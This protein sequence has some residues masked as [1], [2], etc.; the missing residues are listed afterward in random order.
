MNIFY[1]L[2][3]GVVIQYANEVFFGSMNKKIEEIKKNIKRKIQG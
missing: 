3:D 1:F 2:E